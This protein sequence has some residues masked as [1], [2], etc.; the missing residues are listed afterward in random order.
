MIDITAFGAIP[1]TGMLCTQ[2]IQ[3][4]IDA[5]GCGTV[6]IPL[7]EFLTGTINLRSA[8]LYLE[9]GAVLKGSPDMKDYVWNGYQHNEMGKVLSLIY[10]LENQRIRI[11]GEGCIDLNGD[12]FYHLD[13]PNV[14]ASEVPFTAEQLE[15]CTRL[16]D[17]RPNQLIFFYKCR[18]I[19]I[20]GIHI[21]NAPCW[22]ISFVECENIRVLDMTIDNSLRLPN[23]DGMHLCCC[24]HAMIR[25]CNISSGDDC[26]A[27]TCITD[28]NAVCEDVVISDCILRSC[29]KAIVVGYMHSIVRNVC[30]SNVIIRESNRGICVMTSSKT[31]L[32]ENVMVNNARIDTRVRAGNWWGNGEAVCIMGVYHHNTSYTNQPPKRSYPV[33]VRNIIMNGLQCTSE[34]AL[35]IVGEDGNISDIRLL[36][37]SVELKDSANKALKGNRIDLRPGVQSGALPDDG[38][39]YWLC[40]QNVRDILVENA[41][42]APFHGDI[43]GLS[44]NDCCRV[45]IR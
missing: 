8:S 3:A 38:R 37:I 15:E 24:R 29:S 25:G 6:C 43:P 9:K 1:D 32:V 22:T 34:N 40:L 36:N 7:G 16:Y 14:P 21:I 30:I 45:I 41:W 31:G 23:N 19:T 42:I 10:S 4:A 13:R 12:S 44:Q 26:I 39:Y 5:A 2:A 17:A 11:W 27:L 28:W 20:E 18:H 33:N 35:A